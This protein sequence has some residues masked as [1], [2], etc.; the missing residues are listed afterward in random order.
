MSTSSACTQEEEEA[1]YKQ[2][3]PDHHAAFADILQDDS[4][5]VDMDDAIS[6]AAAADGGAGAAEEGAATGA[7]A[8]SA[9]A[10]ALLQGELL[11]DIMSAH[12]RSPRR[13]LTPKELNS[14]H[15]TLLSCIPA[16]REVPG[17]LQ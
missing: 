16:L 7:E 4:M 2:R 13:F 15:I 5:D 6:A 3:F 10:R 14:L 9:A 12:A 17:M 11:R 8:G 1:D